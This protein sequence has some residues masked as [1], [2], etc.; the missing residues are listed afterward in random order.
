M[1][2]NGKEMGLLPKVN[3]M[4]TQF[5][6]PEIESSTNTY[7]TSTSV[8]ISFKAKDYRRISGVGFHSD[9]D[10]CSHFH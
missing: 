6:T 9:S 3:I 7:Q 8:N 5:S 10:S 1:N 2:R 4:K